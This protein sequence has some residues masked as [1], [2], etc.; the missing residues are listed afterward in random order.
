MTALGGGEGGSGEGGKPFESCHLTIK[1]Y[2]KKKKR[3]RTEE[4]K[5]NQMKFAIII[6]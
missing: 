3:N 4:K 5:R 2:G 1:V 6:M